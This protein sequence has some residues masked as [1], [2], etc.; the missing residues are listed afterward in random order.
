MKTIRCTD[1][2]EE[3][4]EEEIESAT[5]CPAC[6]TSSVPMVI[7]ND[8]LL[9]INWHEL[10]ILT[11]WASN[12]AEKLPDDSRMAL[13]KILKR[14]DKH[15]PEGCSALTLVGEIKELQEVFPTASLYVDNELIVPPKE[16]VTH[17][18]ADE[19]HP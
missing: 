5:A 8:V 10:R 11:I 15:R 4:S 3:F 7:K 17:E 6:G 16:D 19:D 12:Y 2:Y 13:H 18:D 9:P 1:C 14:L